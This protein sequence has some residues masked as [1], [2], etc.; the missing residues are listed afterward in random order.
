M[1]RVRGVAGPG[2]CQAVGQL[3]SATCGFALRGLAEQ[4]NGPA[5]P[6]VYLPRLEK[7]PPDA[8]TLNRRRDFLVGVIDS[9]IQLDTVQGDENEDEFIRVASLRIREIV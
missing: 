7:G 1:Q 2:L 5:L 4:V 9:D 8:T 3:R 6:V